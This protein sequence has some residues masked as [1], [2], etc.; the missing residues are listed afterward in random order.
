MPHNGLRLLPSER[1]PRTHSCDCFVWENM[2]VWQYLPPCHPEAASEAAASGIWGIFWGGC[3][4]LCN[5][6]MHLSCGGR[7][8]VFFPVTKV[9][10][11]INGILC[12][13]H[14]FAFYFLLVL[15]FPFGSWRQAADIHHRLCLTMPVPD[16]TAAPSVQLISGRNVWPA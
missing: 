6:A 16:Y 1:A 5:W 11:L 15:S 4:V 9:P 2:A 12:D 10:L 3:C 7:W 14:F 8:L 13:S